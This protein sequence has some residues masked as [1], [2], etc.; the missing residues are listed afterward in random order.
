MQLGL[1]GRVAI[2]A[3]ASQ[4]LGKAVALSLAAE[5][6]KLAICARGEEAL[7]AAAAEISTEC[8]AL[9]VDVTDESQVRSF[10]GAVMQRFGRIDICV[11]NAGGPPA[12]QFE[13]ASLD[14]WQSA[15]H[16][17]FLSVVHF[18]REVLPHMKAARWG[19]FLTITSVSAKQPID[20][21]I[22]SNAVG[23]P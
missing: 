15:Y 19:R 6:A 8:L 21:L 4:G 11:T 18:A 2:V 10:A 23:L 14:D 1:T 3:A 20:G 5:G 22:L 7:Q 13:T 17:N 12:R 9:P 16:L